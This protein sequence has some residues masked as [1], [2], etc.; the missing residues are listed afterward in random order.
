MPARTAARQL[1]R[2]LVT[3]LD[4]LARRLDALVAA[5]GHDAAQLTD[6]RAGQAA[7]VETLRARDAHW[8]R[9][10]LDL[11]AQVEAQTAAIHAE[12]DGLRAEL[13]RLR[14][15]HVEGLAYVA[16]RATASAAGDG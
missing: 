1:L 8:E 16:R 10:V 9:R 5:R 12:L 11:A 13:E 4:E 7:L 6:I 3:R 2:P 15:E 14:G